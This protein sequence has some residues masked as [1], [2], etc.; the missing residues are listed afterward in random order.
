MEIRVEPSN[1]GQF[2]T[3][4]DRQ[5]SL[6]TARETGWTTE[7]IPVLLFTAAVPRQNAIRAQK[8]HGLGCREQFSMRV[9]AEEE[10][11]GGYG[12]LRR[13]ALAGGE[14]PSGT[15]LPPFIL[16]SD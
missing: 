2:E 8:G 16:N 1:S 14:G 12:L 5:A 13:R 6:C 7:A 11:L 15:L 4:W 10:V 3:G 9:A